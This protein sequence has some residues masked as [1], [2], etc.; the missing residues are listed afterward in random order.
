[1][2]TRFSLIVVLS[3]VYIDMLGIGLAFPVLPRLIEEF[4]GGDV[5][6]ASYEPHLD[7]RPA[8]LG[9][10]IRFFRAE[11]DTDRRAGRGVLG[12]GARVRRGVGAR[13]AADCAVLIVGR[14]IRIPYDLPEMLVW[15]LKVARITSPE[16]IVRWLYYRCSGPLCLLHHS[17]DFRLGRY[18][19]AKSEFRGGSW[20]NSH[21]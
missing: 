20:P 4:E 15:V 18:V 6:R 10:A 16:R 19:V 2:P 11:R 17:V 5:S 7:R 8:D 3:V 1:M 12:R 21:A 13:S 14:Q 9:L